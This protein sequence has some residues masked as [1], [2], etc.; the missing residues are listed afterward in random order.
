MEFVDVKVKRATFGDVGDIRAGHGGELNF[1]NKKRAKNTSIV[2]S[3]ETFGEVNYKDF[4]FIHD[5]T[6][7]KAGA[8]LANDVSNNRVGREGADF[9]KYRGDRFVDLFLVPLTK[10]MLPELKNCNI[11]TEIESFFTEIFI[12]EDAGDIE[13]G[14]IWAIEEGKQ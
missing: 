10:F 4:T 6:D 3:D 8:W 2:F 7:I 13:Q 9:I 12:G 1:S 14:G 5:F 11:S